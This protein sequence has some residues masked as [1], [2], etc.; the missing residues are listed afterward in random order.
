MRMITG[1]A[2]ID[3][4]DVHVRGWSVHDKRDRARRHLGYCPQ[5]DA[6]PDKLTVRE[7]LALYAR[8]RGVPAH[9]LQSTVN[10]MIS[11]MCLT[12]HENNTWEHLSGG[13]KR[14]LS[15]A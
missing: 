5:F 1:D 6:L 12:S 7:T 9:L 4:S 14:K 11:R 2:S 3:D 15:T 13:N 10:F 8:I